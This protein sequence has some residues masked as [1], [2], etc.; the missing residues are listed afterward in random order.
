MPPKNFWQKILRKLCKKNKSDSLERV[1]QEKFKDFEATPPENSWSEIQNKLNKKNNSKNIER[2]F[3]EKF[4]DF[5]TTP[6]KDSWAE[7]QN[8]LKEK[9]DTKRVVIPI[10][11]RYSGIAAVLLLCFFVLKNNFDNYNN[12]N[13]FDIVDN[14]NVKNNNTDNNTNTEVVTNEILNNNVVD[15]TNV[16]N[17][18]TDNN[19]NTEIVTNDGFN[20]AVVDNTKTT[21]IEKR[22]ELLIL[23]TE[24]NYDNQLGKNGIN[25]DEFATENQK[26][27]FISIIDDAKTDEKNKV[28]KDLFEEIKL[29]QEE[30]E[31][32]YLS[33]PKSFNKWRI[34]PNAGAVTMNSI[35][36]GSPISDKFTENP[37][38]YQTSMSYGLGVDYSF[39]KKLSIRTGINKLSTAYNTN[40]IVVYVSANRIEVLENA[41]NIETTQKDMVV[42][43]K[44]P[45]SGGN[46]KTEGYINQKMGYIEIPLE[47]S[48]KLLENKFGVEIIG[49]ISTLFLQENEVSVVSEQMKTTLGKAS[50]LSDTHFS[51]NL[52]IGLRY[53]IS[54]SFDINLDP[55]FKYQLGTF[56]KNNGNFKPYLFGVYTGL[57]FKF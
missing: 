13:S 24:N 12:I 29:A 57:S 56:E 53:E 44:R 47:F 9:K 1:F 51:T 50:N 42:A 6:P 30:D 19:T 11:F 41:M 4:K 31:Q 36:E 15:N 7:I 54:K 23:T 48:Y 28:K 5:E 39:T 34:T 14:T 46:S 45:A 3:Q 40:D 16:K 27:D 2:I 17:N 21:E 8:R 25:K 49:G 20:N 32:L 43:A 10:W 35:S 33:D 52:G 38:D 26:N 18:N 55:M 22:N 37:K